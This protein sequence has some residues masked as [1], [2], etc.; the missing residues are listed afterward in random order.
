MDIPK[1]ATK[2]RLLHWVYKV[3]DLKHVLETLHKEFNIKVLRH[4][5]FNS[6]CEATCNGNFDNAWSKTMAGLGDEKQ[7]F[8]LELVFNYGKK[9]AYV[10]HYGMQGLEFLDA[11]FSGVQEVPL[12][13]YSFLKMGPEYMQNYLEF[14]NFSSPPSNNQNRFVF[15]T[16]NVAN[17]EKSIHYY[18]VVLG[19][20]IFSKTLK[21]QSNGI[22]DLNSLDKTQIESLPESFKNRNSA[23]FCIVGFGK[24]Q[25]LLKIVQSEKPIKHDED[26]GRMA[27]TCITPVTKI[28]EKV[29]SFGEK[30]LHQPVV[31]KTEGK[32]DVKVVI[33]QDP[34]GY[35]ICFVEEEGFHDLCTTKEGDE[36]IHWEQRQAVLEKIK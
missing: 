11:S 31:L 14:L 23:K 30:I 34:D 36:V 2:R 19:M 8:A 7:H 15:L 10:K 16:L 29:E 6:I 33:L 9:G 4:E 3:Q 1:Q 21:G 18:T 13:N 27:F 12:E 17:L 32:A 20:T 35:E 24:D 22:V 25:T 26:S 28:K 5:E